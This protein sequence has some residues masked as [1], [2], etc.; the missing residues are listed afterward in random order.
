MA[1]RKRPMSNTIEGAADMLRNAKMQLLQPEPLTEAE[2]VIFRHIV[3]A[4]E[5]ASWTTYDLR[6]ACS[7]ARTERRYNEM[8][9]IIDEQGYTTINDRGTRVAN[10]IVTMMKDIRATANM[11]GRQLGLSATQRGLNTAEQGKR[12]AADGAARKVLAR[13]K[14]EA[15]DDLI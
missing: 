12:N 14:E 2:L 7:L 6:L 3:A 9:A 15:E 1:E 10:P 8:S 13:A 4:R 5:T 11:V